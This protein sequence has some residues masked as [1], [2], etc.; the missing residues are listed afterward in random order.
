MSAFFRI[1]LGFIIMAVGVL[2]VW[3]TIWFQDLVGVI[4]WAE[5]KIG[6]GGT[7]SFLKILGIIVIFI[8]IATVTNMIS[9][10]LTDFV[11]IFIRK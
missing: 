11:S 4:D 6:P 10:I 3:K 2:M 7:N 5:E 1:P 8:G 9:D